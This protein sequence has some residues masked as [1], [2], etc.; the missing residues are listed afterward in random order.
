MF[1]K[2]G[3]STAFFVLAHTAVPGAWNPSFALLILIRKKSS[4]LIRLQLV[5]MRISRLQTTTCAS[6][7]RGDH[8]CLC[9]NV[10]LWRHLEMASGTRRCTLRGCSALVQVSGAQQAAATKARS[11]RQVYWPRNGCRMKNLSLKKYTT[12]RQA[13]V[14]RSSS[15]ALMTAWL[16]RKETFQIV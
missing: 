9:L 13:L 1:R 7:R 16:R 8:Q 5:D 11:E 2:S 10:G 15:T 6:Y 14:P 3:R 4:A 12:L